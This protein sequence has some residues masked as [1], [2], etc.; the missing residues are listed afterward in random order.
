MQRGFVTLENLYKTKQAEVLSLK[1]ALQEKCDEHEST[2]T[3]LLDQ[4]D[5][6]EEKIKRLSAEAKSKCHEVEVLSSELEAARARTRGVEPV[7]IGET[8]ESVSWAGVAHPGFL[9]CCSPSPQRY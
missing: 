9:P 4:L 1:Q 6:H 3:E 7:A 5:L 2:T 8:K